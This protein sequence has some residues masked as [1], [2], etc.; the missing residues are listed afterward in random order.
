[1]TR[2][3][4]EH[5]APPGWEPRDR[6]RW[7]DSSGFWR[8]SWRCPSYL[9][10][11]ARQC[12][13]AGVDKFPHY[14]RHHTLPV[15]VMGDGS[16]CRQ[17]LGTRSVER[18]E[19][20]VAEAERQAQEAAAQKN[21]RP[22]TLEDVVNSGELGKPERLRELLGDDAEWI[23]WLRAEV[24]SGLA[25]IRAGNQ[26]EGEELLGAALV[27]FARLMTVCILDELA[28]EAT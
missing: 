3:I 25:E 21:G 11:T 1:M 22:K 27:D 8:E 28:L 24:R 5:T 23:D 16:K 4:C 26:P 2:P 12:L 10:H 17:C 6:I 13:T 15:E 7:Q 18:A 14:C 9:L 20:K 19:V